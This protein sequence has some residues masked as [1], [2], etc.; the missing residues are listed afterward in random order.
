VTKGGFRTG[1]TGKTKVSI[2][3]KGA[4]IPMPAPASMGELFDQDTAVTVQL[5]N[6]QTST[7]WTSEFTSSIKNDGAQYKA[8]F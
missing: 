1:T 4:N 7:C 5:I 2:G 6:D 8:K 3:A